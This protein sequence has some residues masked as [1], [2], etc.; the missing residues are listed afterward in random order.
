M[1]CHL[2]IGR[3]IR[4][5]KAAPRGE[6]EHRRGGGRRQGQE[7]AVHGFQGL[8]AIPDPDHGTVKACTQG[9]QQGRFGRGG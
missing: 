1:A 7:V 8:L 5:R 6:I 9:P 4:L 2:D 3:V